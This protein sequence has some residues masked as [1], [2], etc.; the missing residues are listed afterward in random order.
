MAY[1]R[2]LKALYASAH[3]C[4]LRGGREE[5]R[6]GE[7]ESGERRRDGEERE[8]GGIRSEG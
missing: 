6:E 5:G 4:S 2:P 1:Q 7:R 3:S 8:G